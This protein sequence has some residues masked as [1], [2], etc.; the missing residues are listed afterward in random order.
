MC[1]SVLGLSVLKPVATSFGQEYDGLVSSSNCVFGGSFLLFHTSTART[2]VVVEVERKRTANTPVSAHEIQSEDE[3][4]SHL[5]DGAISL[6]W[7]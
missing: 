1:V 3:P 2:M 7:V 6:R 4:L 5:G